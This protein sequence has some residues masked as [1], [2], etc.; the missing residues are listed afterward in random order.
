MPFRP[1]AHV[2]LDSA[3]HVLH[4]RIVLLPELLPVLRAGTFDLSRRFRRDG[5]D[6]RGCYF[7]ILRKK[8]GGRGHEVVLCASVPAMPSLV[9]RSLHF[10]LHLRVEHFLCVKPLLIVSE[11]FHCELSF[12]QRF[13]D[14]EHRLELVDA[15][16]VYLQMQVRSAVALVLCATSD[17]HDATKD[18]SARP[19]VAAE[20]VLAAFAA[21]VAPRAIRAHAH[22]EEYHEAELDLHL[23]RLDHSVR[24]LCGRRAPQVVVRELDLDVRFQEKVLG[25]RH[26]P[27]PILAMPH[28][29]IVPSVPAEA[30]H[31]GGVLLVRRHRQEKAVAVLYPHPELA[32]AHEP[33]QRLRSRQLPAEVNAL[34]GDL[35][36]EIRE[37]LRVRQHRDVAGNRRAVDSFKIRNTHRGIDE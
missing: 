11:L 21:E 4:V 29:R 27:L 32:M 18:A 24:V 1:L 16:N 31:Q 25:S 23:V 22:A 28:S 13:R 12:L 7:A 9:S 36:L 33:S 10:L 26:P 15:R 5:D 8:L 34:S 35:P 37:A 14:L 3:E 30:K 2:V 19:H 17:G 6:I 20:L